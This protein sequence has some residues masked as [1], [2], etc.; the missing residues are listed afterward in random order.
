MEISTITFSTNIYVHSAISGTLG[1]SHVEALV[2]KI[3]FREQNDPLDTGTSASASLEI[4]SEI[5]QASG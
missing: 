1:Y 2:I 3:P 5:K 4:D